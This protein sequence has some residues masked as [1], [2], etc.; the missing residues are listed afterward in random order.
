MRFLLQQQLDGHP[1]T[2]S[3]PDEIYAE[4]V[5]SRI[6]DAQSTVA[7]NQMAV[8]WRLLGYFKPYR[9]EVAHDLRQEVYAHLQ[10]VAIDGVDL[11]SLDMAGTDPRRGV[12]CA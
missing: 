4:A 2:P 3:N 7:K 10:K 5:A 1:V 9:K 6:R 8:V 12:G 11:N